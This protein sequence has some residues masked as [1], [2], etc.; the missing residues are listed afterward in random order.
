MSTS[1]SELPLNENK[2]HHDQ[3]CPIHP[4]WNEIYYIGN[5]PTTTCET[6]DCQPGDTCVDDAVEGPQCVAS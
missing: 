1:L 5:N 3:T 2:M 6:V 4:N